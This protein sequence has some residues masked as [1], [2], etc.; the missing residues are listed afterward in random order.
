MTMYRS[1]NAV[2]T[3]ARPP[4][5]FSLRWRYLSTRERGSKLHHHLSL[6]FWYIHAFSFSISLQPISCIQHLTPWSKGR[7]V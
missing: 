2:H 5:C 1:E 3:R 6:S 4:F 7:K